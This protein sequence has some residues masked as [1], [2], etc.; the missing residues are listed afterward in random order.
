MA[1]NFG[2]IDWGKVIAGVQSA[3]TL[4]EELAPAA[5]IAGPEGAVIGGIVSNI[6]KWS[7][8]LLTLA[9]QAGTVLSSNDLAAIQSADAAIQ[10]QNNS[11]SQQIADS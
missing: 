8:S 9:Q 10:V 7:S 4:V 1:F 5:A 6:A 2:S 11:L 3:A